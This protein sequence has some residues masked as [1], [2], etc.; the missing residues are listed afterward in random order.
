MYIR[1]ALVGIAC[2]LLMS[3]KAGPAEVCPSGSTLVGH[4]PPKGYETVCM[5]TDRTKHGKETKWYEN[6]T[7]ES[8]IEFRDGEPHGKFTYWSTKGVKRSEGENRRGKLHGTF[9]KWRKDG[10]KWKEATFDKGRATALRCWPKQGGPPKVM[11]GDI[12]GL[13]CHE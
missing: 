8:E 12:G 5:K 6:G 7:K 9:V 3:C 11:S 4:P 2:L 13:R 1:T 10:Q